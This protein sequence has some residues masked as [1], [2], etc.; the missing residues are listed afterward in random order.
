MRQQTSSF[1]LIELLIVVAILAVLSV[2]IILVLNP[3]EL[4]KQARDANRLTELVA[5]NK[6]LNIYQVDVSSGNMGTSSVIYISIPDS[7]ATTTAGTDCSSFG[8]SPPSGWSYHCAASSTYKNVDGLGWIPVN[9]TQMSTKSPLGSLPVDPVNTTS[10]GNYYTYVAGG[11][12]E[13]ATKMESAKYR[14]GGSKDVVSK[15]GGDNIYL[16]EVGTSLSLNPYSERLT[17]ANFATGDLT[18]WNDWATGGTSGIVNTPTHWTPK[19]AIIQGSNSYC[20]NY[21]VQD[22]PVQTNTVYSIGAWVKTVNE[23]GGAYVGIANTSWGEWAASPTITGTQDWTYLSVTT[24]SGANT[25]LRFWLSVTWCGG[26]PPGLGPS[27]TSY[28][29]D[30]SVVAGGVLWNK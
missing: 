28:F 29:A 4:L 2:I 11:S 30:A 3:A 25:V 20:N 17:N 13:L 21:Y 5:I 18:G 19:S 23:V 16:Y 7:S 12:W 9:F 1:T 24:N 8:L 26:P 22:L 15:D 27:G 10:S 14:V 6:A